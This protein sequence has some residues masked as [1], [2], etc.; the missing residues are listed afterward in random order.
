MDG[1]FAVVMTFL[2]LNISIPQISSHSVD[3]VRT[4]LLKRLFDLWPKILSYASYAGILLS[5]L[6]TSLKD[7]RCTYNQSR[8]ASIPKFFYLV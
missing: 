7:V 8:Q 4:E 5:L 3:I 2:V 1:I 6:R